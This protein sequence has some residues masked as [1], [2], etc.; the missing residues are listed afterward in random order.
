MTTTTVIPPG[1]QPIVD[2]V[3]ARTLSQTDQDL[4]AAL[5]D[6]L[7]L[8]KQPYREI[9]DRLG[10]TEQEVIRRIVGLVDSGIFKRFG[11]VVRHHELGYRAN[12]MVV[13][14]VPDERVALIGTMLAKQPEVRLCYRRPRQLPDWPYNLFCMIHGRDPEKVLAILSR[15]SSDLDLDKYQREVLFSTHRYK[16]RGARYR[17][18]V[19]N[20]GQP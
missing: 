11:V 4:I 13:W 1:P 16:Q 15:I 7:P 8:V 2:D 6:G 12:G 3:G 5:Q 14:D 9:A 18:A 20:R 19:D 10:M 17:Y